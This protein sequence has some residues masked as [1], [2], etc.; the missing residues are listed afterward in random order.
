MTWRELYCYWRGRHIDGRPPSRADIDPPIDIPKLLANLIILDRVGAHC[1][2]R[3]AGSDV[4]RRGGRDAT[5]RTLEGD[6][7]SYRRLVMLVEFLER[8]I[9]TGE[10]VIYSVARGNDSAFAAIGILLP[11]TSAEA[12]M[13]LGGVFYRTTRTGESSEPWTPGAFAELPL[14]HMLEQDIE[15]F[16]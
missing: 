1:R 11:L 8:V 13:V 3:L 15:P 12:G 4:V 9:T 14:P 10:P 7:M 5:G 6:M 2:I 16:R